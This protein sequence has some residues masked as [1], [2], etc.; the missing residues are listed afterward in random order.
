MLQSSPAEKKKTSWKLFSKEQFLSFSIATLQDFSKMI[1]A[2]III[3]M[4]MIFKI[5]FNGSLFGQLLQSSSHK[6]HETEYL[7]MGFF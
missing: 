1:T 3:I 6:M 7:V 4:M 2:V 5:I